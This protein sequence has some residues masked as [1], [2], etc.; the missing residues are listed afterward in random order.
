MPAEAKQGRHVERFDVEVG[1]DVAVLGRGGGRSPRGRLRRGRRARVDLR[2]VRVLIVVA[3]AGGG[4][5]RTRGIPSTARGV[6]GV[7]ST[8]RH[9]ALRQAVARLNLALSC[10][11]EIFACGPGGRGKRTSAMCIPPTALFQGHSRDG[12]RPRH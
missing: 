3:R 9:S 2:E 5:E 8:A 4:G 10:L 11:G 6:L 1:A 12:A 7:L